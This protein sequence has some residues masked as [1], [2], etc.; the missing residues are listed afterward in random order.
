MKT[1]NRCG[2]EKPD[3]DFARRKASRDGLQFKCRVCDAVVNKAW[4]TDNPE[5]SQANTRAWNL[6]N[7]VHIAARHRKYIKD[8]PLYQ[9]E[10]SAKYRQDNP[11]KYRAR[12]KLREAVRTGRLTRPCLCQFCG[13]TGPIEAHHRDYN[14]PLHVQW[15]CRPCHHG[16]HAH[17]IA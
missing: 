2:L 9:A 4:H 8:H 6:A 12:I 3:T 7:K 14:E 10:S 11:I 16:E 13:G 5:Q 17:S 1:C 15:L